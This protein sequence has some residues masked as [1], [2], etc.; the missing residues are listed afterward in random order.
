MGELKAATKKVAKNEEIY[1]G[2]LKKE[3]VIV[4]FIPKPTKEITNPNHIAYGGKLNDTYDHIAPPRLNKAKMKNILTNEEKK[5]LEHL[6]GR[7][8]S[9]YGDFWKGYRKGGLFPIPLGK[10]DKELNLEVPEDYIIWKVLLNTN[11]VANSS[12]QFKNE[13]RASYKWVMVKEQETNIV[14]ETRI[15]DKAE[16]FEFYNEIKTDASILRYVLRS[17]GKHTHVKQDMSFLRK[18]VGLAIESEKHR[19]III[20]LKDDAQLKEKV[21]LEEAVILG[22]IDRVSGQF[23]TKDGDP[24]CGKGDEPTEYNSSKFLGLSVGQEMRL[25]IEARIKNAKN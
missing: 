20:G 23:Y 24:I 19:K 10:E 7:D 11:L 22:V 25:A 5:G 21:L 9:I 14:E 16:A 4:Q 6:M 13:Y 17:L 2:F 15:S 12:D 1:T 18:E 3:K 8:L